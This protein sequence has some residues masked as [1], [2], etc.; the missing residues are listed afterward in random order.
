MNC[1]TNFQHPL[2]MKMLN[3]V[4]MGIN[5]LNSIKLKQEKSTP[6]IILN[7]QRMKGFFLQIRSKGKMP[8]LTVTSEH[9][10]GHFS[11]C[12]SGQKEKISKHPKRKK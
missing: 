7:D 8:V 6:I 10:T 5:Y 1:L 11:Q 9:G 12:D 2:M 4:G 3:K